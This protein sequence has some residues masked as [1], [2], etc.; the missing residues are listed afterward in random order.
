M[1]VYLQTNQDI[2][3]PNQAA[4]TVS[5]AD[6][7]KIFIL[8]QTVAGVGNITISLPA[9]APGLHFRFIN[10]SPAA[11]VRNVAITATA[12]VVYGQAIMGPLNGVA[13][14]NIAGVPPAGL[15]TLN[16]VTGVTVLGDSADYY[17]DGTRWYVNA[18][19]TTA[20]SFTAA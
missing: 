8:P 12:A 6:T 15:T 3:V 18:Y 14:L 17:C 7:G 5:T 19:A 10:S 4:Y 9:P 2:L 13:F 1:S 20:G 11:S 16:F